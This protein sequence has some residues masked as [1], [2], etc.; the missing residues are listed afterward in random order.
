MTLL[1]ISPD[2]ASHLLPLATL[3]TAWRDAGE[4]VVVATGPATASIVES[5]GFERVNLQLGKGSNPG[6]IRPEDQ[7]K[8]EDDALRG[9]FDATRRG[10]VE[11]LSFQ[12]EARLSD[13]MWEP[14][15][16]AREVQAVVATVQPDTIIVDHLAFSARLAL[17]AGKVK[18]A[19][20]VLGHPSAL[21]IEGEVYGFPPAWPAAFSPS[22]A[23]LAALRELCE[24]V[25]ASFTAE[26][27]AA[28]AELDPAAT[29]SKSAFAEHGELLLLN[30]P[31]E[32]SAP[33]EGA[34]FLGS[35]VRT[36]A[37]D[38]E[39]EAWLA[40][41]SEPFFYVSFG[42]FL[43]VRADVLQRV[44]DALASLGLRAAI[45][46]GESELTDVP[47]GWLVRGFLPQVRL[48]GQAAA[49]VTH[50]GNN[51][52]TEAMT[53]G[54]PLVVLPFSTDQFAGAAAIEDHGF[55]VALAPNEATVEDLAAAVT[56]VLAIGALPIDLRSAPGAARAYSAVKTS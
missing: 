49:A 29:P 5:F 11:T 37:V 47:E 23:E 10:M 33:R 17:V 35:A 16:V 12:A 1:I 52:V 42:S 54:V 14:V 40:S 46:T 53:F 55:G 36:E 19:D 26:W 21:P 27:N 48:L 3:G 51:S 18:F 20:V 2:Y 44:A 45:A 28:L 38:D 15:R 24:R 50:G 31:E 43:S 7:P 4:R 41:S 30:Y 56:E 13:L 22:A 25:D 9:F 34:I 8:G 39:V 6:T 32:L